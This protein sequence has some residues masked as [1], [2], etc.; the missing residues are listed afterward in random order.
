M[1]LLPIF[2]G[3]VAG[4]CLYAAVF[5]LLVGFRQQPY[6]QTS[7]IFS[8]LA[9]FVTATI[10][11][12]GFYRLAIT[13]ASAQLALDIGI[14]L[15]AFSLIAFLWF[16]ASYTSIKP[17]RFLW[18]MSGFFIFAGILNLILPY[19]IL[20]AKITDLYY[21]TMPW[22]E[23]FAV[24]EGTPNNWQLLNITLFL[25]TFG[26][27]F[28]A[29]YKQY[30][31][32]ERRK[33]TVLLLGLLPIILGTAFDFL[34][35]FG[36]I[37]HFIGL[38]TISYVGLVLIMSLGMS[39]E[40]VRN[41]NLQQEVA[42]SERR[43]RTLLENVEL[44]VIGLDANGRINYT[45]PFYSKI[46][47]FNA[48]E[49]LGRDFFGEFIPQ[50]T[51]IDKAVTFAD[52]LDAD[53]PRHFQNS[54]ATKNSAERIIAWANVR[55]R[56][57]ENQ[58]VG[59]LSIGID[60]TEQIATNETLRTQATVLE[61]MQEGVNV[62]DLQ[63]EILF[64]NKAFDVMFGYDH[65][66]LIGKHV[67]VLNVLE[68]DENMQ[69]VQKIIAE[70]QKNKVWSGEFQNV[71]KD[72][73]AMITS[74]VI[75]QLDIAEKPHWVSVQTD[76]SER[77]Q[78]EAEL[79][80]H[81]EHLEEL[82][83]ERTAELSR[84]VTELNTLNQ[85]ARVVAAFVDLQTTLQRVCTIVAP[86]FDAPLVVINI[87]GHKQAR[88]HLT[89]GYD[90]E[91]KNHIAA[92]VGQTI[93]I[94]TASMLQQ[95]L[96]TEEPFIAT[97]LQENADNISLILRERRI[98]ALMLIPLRRRT[99]IIGVLGILRD[100]QETQFDHADVILAET[101]A[102]YVAGAIENTR[103]T[104]QLA[105]TAVA[106]ERSRIA[107]DLHDSVT[108]NLYTVATISEALPDLWD[109]HPEESRKALGNLQKL[110]RGALAEMRILL[111]ELRPT[112]IL[113]K[114]LGQLLQQLGESVEGRSH[115]QV[116]TTI[117]GNQIFPDDVQVALYRIAQEALNNVIKHSEATQVTI[118]LYQVDE[119][120]T[121]RVRD[122][123]LGFEKGTAVDQTAVNGGFGLE[124]IRERTRQIDAKLTIESKPEAGTEISIIWLAVQE[125][126]HE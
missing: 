6:N 58:V 60:M 66:E 83:T 31:Q 113:E 92:G 16:I 90:R 88:V 109:T 123:G 41:S 118:G 106:K 116:T 37:T 19:G 124:N 43:M 44:V 95:V 4:I 84:A 40:V 126:T 61:N 30:Q 112:S 70:L 89:A 85:I 111:L 105:D 100:Q 101:V 27:S 39:D 82:V 78:T 33:A 15:T 21:E 20:Y 53:T 12:D 75:S 2:Y 9:F 38:Y 45:N 46:T 117:V 97:G 104:Q 80:A 68:K 114:P 76:I 125:E 110:S 62:T 57:T 8:I 94:E 51:Q 25:L 52:F 10:I 71:R 7:I 48:D 107:R 93:P 91:T 115:I 119:M 5:H 34:I 36:V 73:A 55:L 67:S 35:D 108:Q 98:D 77:K 54:I 13:V 56:N 23:L 50:N 81:R 99:E 47:G 22:G 29:I 49:V 42:E 103:L 72:G 17:K 86:L 24:V 87:F 96:Q 79:T 1:V 32:G 120:V 18:V 3:L 14:S 28:F 63:G 64:T 26:Y 102:G 65:D 121:L 69:L 74:A 122:N 11:L 59:I